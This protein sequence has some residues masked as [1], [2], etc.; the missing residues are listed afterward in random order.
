[1]H[2]S[3]LRKVIDTQTFQILDKF[4]SFSVLGFDGSVEQL[5]LVGVGAFVPF[6]AQILQLLV[7]FDEGK[8]SGVDPVGTRCW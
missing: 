4:L 3:R 8:L 7:F 1:V 5:L 2:A 6:F